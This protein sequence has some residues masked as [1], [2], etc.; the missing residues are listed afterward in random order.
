MDWLSCYSYRLGIRNI[1]AKPESEKR[2]KLEMDFGGSFSFFDYTDNDFCSGDLDAI[3][4]RIFCL[5]N[6]EF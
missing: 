5:W 2:Y 3:Q 4:T 1:Q 6:E